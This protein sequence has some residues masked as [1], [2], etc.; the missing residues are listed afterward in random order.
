MGLT[1][2]R[3]TSLEIMAKMLKTKQTNK[4]VFTIHR[5]VEM[6]VSEQE[7]WNM[8]HGFGHVDNAPDFKKTTIW[9]G[10]YEVKEKAVIDILK[11]LLEQQK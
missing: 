5:V 9:Q 8:E 7:K 4:Y 3:A 1:R 2:L 10:E 11:S 6:E